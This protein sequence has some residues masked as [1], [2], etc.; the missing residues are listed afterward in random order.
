LI[1]ILGPNPIFGP[2]TWWL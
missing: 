2:I 1:F